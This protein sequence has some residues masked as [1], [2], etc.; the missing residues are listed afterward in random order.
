[1]PSV[2]ALFPVPSELHA[3]D[4]SV[5]SPQ[6]CPSH[7][8][9]QQLAQAA[10]LVTKIT[11]LHSRL[12][13]LPVPAESFLLSQQLM[14]CHYNYFWLTG[15]VWV[16]SGNAVSVS[17]AKI[18]WKLGLLQCLFSGREGLP[19]L[20]LESPAATDTEA[21]LGAPRG[22]LVALP[23]FTEVMSHSRFSGSLVAIDLMQYFI[24]K[25]GGK[26][27]STEQW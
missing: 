2:T 17:R 6:Q 24:A 19:S 25:A 20:S 18:L 8:R 14:N 16:N 7:Y 11:Y 27:T 10:C 15:E 1:M 26:H 12:L 3:G 5:F 9:Q 21:H 23:T 22:S 13:C 4:P